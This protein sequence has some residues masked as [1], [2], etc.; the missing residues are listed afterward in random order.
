MS[1]QQIKSIIFPQIL[2]ALSGAPAIASSRTIDAAGEWDGLVL[3]AERDMTISHV[4][5]LPF[6]SSTGVAEIRIETV[7][8]A[9]G[10]PTGTLWGTNTNGVSGT[11]VALS[12]EL[13][14]LTAAASISAGDVFAV[15]IKY[16][17]GTSFQPGYIS[18]NGFSGGAPYETFNTGAGSSLGDGRT[19]CLALGSD[20]TTFYPVDACIPA[21]AYSSNSFNN[22]DAARRG[23]RFKLPFRARVAGLRHYH[24][25]INGDVDIRLY[26][27]AGT[28]LTS[29]AVDGS[30]NQTGSNLWK[31]LYFSTPQ[32][33]EPDTWYRAVVVPASATNSAMPYLTLPSADYRR[34]MPGGINAHYTTYT[35]LGG[36]VDTDTDKVPLLDLLIDQLGDDAGGAGG[37]KNHPGLS[38]GLIT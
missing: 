20:A 5:F 18:G 38:G 33:I 29:K 32:I 13:V 8:T 10:K 11:L 34:A 37:V 26:D 28:Q 17:S 2:T 9:D 24:A 35:T 31:R 1:L 16:S 7:S 21:T 4:G 22:T 27:D 36:W 3:R 25:G 23:L 12:W 15:L 30:Q 6:A 14:A 19:L